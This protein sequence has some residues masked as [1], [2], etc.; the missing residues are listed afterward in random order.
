MTAVNYLGIPKVEIRRPEP[1]QAKIIAELS[2]KEAEKANHILTLIYHNADFMN[3]LVD[4]LFHLKLLTRTNRT[5]FKETQKASQ[6]I[7]S[8][9]VNESVK[10]GQD[11]ERVMQQNNYERFFKQLLSLTP[12]E[13]DKVMNYT[14]NVKFE[15]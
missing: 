9:F 14:D 7:L 5:T 6:E 10:T 12:K 15:K 4:V 2:E 8:Y 11:E 13:F 1:K 3:D